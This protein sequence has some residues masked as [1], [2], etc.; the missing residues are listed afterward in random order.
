M[1]QVYQGGAGLGLPF[2]QRTSPG[3]AT[4]GTSSPNGASE[5]SVPPCGAAL[6]PPGPYMVMVGPYLTVQYLDPVT[7]TW[8]P[9]TSVTNNTA[10][11]I[12]D[13]VNFRIFNPT[14]AVLGAAVTNAGSGA[15]SG[16][17]SVSPST[18][19]STWA[20]VVGGAC[21]TTIPLQITVAGGTTTT[22][23]GANYTIAPRV[24]I[25]APPAPGVQATAYATIASGTVSGI[26]VTNQG[27]GYLSVVVTTN[28]TTT[29]CCNTNVALI[30]SPYDPNLGAITNATAG[31]PPL[32]GAGTITA[33][34]C[35]NSGQAV[36]SAPT[37]TISGA[38]AAAATAILCQTATSLTLTSGGAGYGANNP[39]TSGG[40]YFNTT[41]YSPVLTNPATDSMLLVPRPLQALVTTVNSSTAPVI[42][43]TSIKDGGLFVAPPAPIVL[44]S[45]VV[46]TAATIGVGLGTAPGTAY[47]QPL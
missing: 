15:V 46:T 43:A 10:Y 34:L 3:L 8:L 35:T 38:G 37:L 1:S 30:P 41:S 47:L 33:L 24:V 23:Y 27:A 7:T 11:I 2:P 31:T 9:Y 13:G 40:G 26:T 5:L 18:G 28:G 42:T 44:S 29:T 32:T 39:I 4:S 20:A 17:V 36:S 6:I 45:A 22:L 12:S 14:G 19:N 21:T 25:D 16:S